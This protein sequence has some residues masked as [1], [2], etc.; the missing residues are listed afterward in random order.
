[1]ND[2]QRFLLR[3]HRLTRRFFPGLGAAGSAALASWPRNGRAEV[4]SPALE[5]AIAELE[6]FFT[7][8]A[9]FRDVSRGKPLPHS[10]PDEKK[11]EVG[12]TRE[13]WKLEVISDPDNPAKLARELTKQDGT[14]LDFAGLLQLAEKHAV[15]FA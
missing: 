12:L 1:M 11:R 9:A 13:N 3:H 2:F 8:Q 14:A 15:R 5:K 6:S 4:G 10:L 7:P